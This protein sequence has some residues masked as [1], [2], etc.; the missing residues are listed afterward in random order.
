MDSGNWRFPFSPLR[1]ICA[2]Q[3]EFTSPAPL[4]PT[5]FPVRGFG[6]KIEYARKVIGGQ[7]QRQRNMLLFNNFRQMWQLERF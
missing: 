2:P 3:L 5:V 1:K 6:R 4:N 7:G